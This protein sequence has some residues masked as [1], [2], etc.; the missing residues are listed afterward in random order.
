MNFK[1]SM[2]LAE[3]LY[4]KPKINQFK[5]N[6]LNNCLFVFDKLT[7]HLLDVFDQ[8]FQSLKEQHNHN[9]RGSHQY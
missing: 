1:Q 9:T 5:N 2:E 3:P 4:Q 6:I 7:N 8:F